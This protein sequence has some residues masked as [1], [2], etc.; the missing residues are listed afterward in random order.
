MQT[1]FARRSGRTAHFAE[2]QQARP[3]RDA[4]RLLMCCDWS[5]GPWAPI[6]SE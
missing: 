3:R 4:A 1:A 2:H 6:V 5:L